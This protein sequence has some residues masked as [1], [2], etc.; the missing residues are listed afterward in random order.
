MAVKEN[1]AD[2]NV[3]YSADLNSLG[4]QIN[5]TAT[6][7]SNNLY[8]VL[9]YDAV[10]E[11]SKSYDITADTLKTGFFVIVS[12]YQVMTG[13]TGSHGY[14]RVNFTIQ[15]NAIETK[16]FTANMN[17]NGYGANDNW[18][19]VFYA[20][21]DTIATLDFTS[22][23]TVAISDSGAVGMATHITNFTI[24]GVEV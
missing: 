9:T 20:S 14:G 17:A 15:G 10:D 16:V 7:L 22:T 23:I 12:G 13:V 8:T 24:L 18:S 2:G 3:L 19:F 4:V 5:A 1:W 6:L 21:T 11:S